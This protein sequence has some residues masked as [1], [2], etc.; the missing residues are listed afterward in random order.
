MFYTSTRDKS[1]KVT[2]AEAITKG[3]S[4]EGGLFVPC[5]V[6]Q[7]DLDFIASMKD[8]SYIERAKKVLSLYLTDFTEEEISYCVN[9]AY[10]NSFASAD[11]APVHF[12]NDT[13]NIFFLS[14]RNNVCLQCPF[15]MGILCKK[16]HRPTKCAT[17]I[18]LS[19]G[20]LPYSQARS[21]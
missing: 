4:E 8:M 21:G 18:C 19:G 16:Y 9:G 2:S 14:S 12:L 7:I 10:E 11:V 6:P 15:L 20:F 5:E 13:A 17:R 1:L 3:I